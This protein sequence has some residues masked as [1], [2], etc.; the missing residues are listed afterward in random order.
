[1]EI[2]RNRKTQMNEWSDPGSCNATALL[3]ASWCWC[4]GFWLPADGLQPELPRWNMQPTPLSKVSNLIFSQVSPLPSLKGS[5]FSQRFSTMLSKVSKQPF[6]KRSQP[7]PKGCCSIVKM[8]Y[9]STTNGLLW[10]F[11]WNLFCFSVYLLYIMAPYFAVNLTS[12]LHSTWR[13]ILH[14]ICRFTLHS[15][16]HNHNTL[17]YLL[18]CYLTLYTTFFWH[19][20]WPFSLYILS[21]GS[22]GVKLPTDRQMQQQRWEESGK[23]KEEE[24]RSRRTKR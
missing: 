13:L 14:S 12:I 1:M 5:A 3:E 17:K 16:W 10:H 18:T 6:L 7:F 4:L 15:I 19:S 11:I 8:V 9:I 21:E 23:R 22:L 24:R 2:N 20:I